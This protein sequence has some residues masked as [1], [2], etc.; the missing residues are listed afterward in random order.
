G[1]NEIEIDLKTTSHNHEKSRKFKFDVALA[2]CNRNY[3]SPQGRII[4]QG[5]TDCW[6]TINVP[7]G[8]T[9]SLYFNGMRLFDI[10]E[11]ARSNLQIHDGDFSAPLLATLCGMQTPSPVFSTGNKLSL[12]SISDRGYTWENY[13][14]TYTSTDKGQGCGGKIYNYNG[15]FTSP[16][17]PN[18]YRNSSSCVWDVSVPR[19]FIITLEFEYFNIG[20]GDCGTDHLSVS[21]VRES[22]ASVSLYCPNDNPSK[23]RSLSNEVQI[24]YVTS[25]NNGGNGWIINF[26][27][28]ERSVEADD[29]ATGADDFKYNPHSGGAVVLG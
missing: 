18:N 7:A 28:V 15:R 23:Y 19:G 16:L 10:N 13:D 25:V 9:I 12:H 1:S 29:T 8:N 2:N 22:T 6:I 20:S 4:H 5:F 27:A 21:D 17:Y 11:C 24:T 14:I 26:V 3:T